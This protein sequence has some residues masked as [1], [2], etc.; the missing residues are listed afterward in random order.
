MNVQR[1]HIG[2]V[3]SCV[4]VAVFAVSAQG[5]I[6][7]DRPEL[8]GDSAGALLVPTGI[9]SVTI[10]E[11]ANLT[12]N[13]RDGSQ[14]TL[15]LDGPDEIRQVCPISRDR[16]LVF[17]PVRGGD[18]Y[19]V[20]ILSLADG[21]IL[22]IFGA[23]DPRVSPDQ[24]WLVSR[25]RYPTVVELVFEEYVLYDLSKDAKA[26]EAPGFTPQKRPSPGR[27]V[28]PITPN[29]KRLDHFDIPPPE[30]RHEFASQSI[31]WS[32]DSRFLAFGDRMA[33]E[34][35]V[36]VI[37]L[38][39]K[40]LPAYVHRLTLEELCTGRDLA[41]EITEHVTLE[42]VEF[43]SMEDNL[44]SLRA[45]FSFD[46][47]PALGSATCTKAPLLHSRNLTRAPVEMHKRMRSGR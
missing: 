4:L 42:K 14:K 12:I 2:L 35:S 29:H 44:P 18:G 6:A 30:L 9:S 46:F 22:D 3:R 25:V 38:G 23:R 39:K 17:G 40:E 41:P 16:L 32:P 37:D 5:Q 8:C 45:H 7:Q 21:S 47:G 36:V 31:F 34:T 26:N 24:H 43:G 10:P 15:E 13:L 28:F 33:H 27:I 1:G 19:I 11:G 20:W